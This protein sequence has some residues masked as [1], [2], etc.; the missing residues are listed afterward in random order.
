VSLGAV[1][2][3]N[4]ASGKVGIAVVH[5]GARRVTILGA[6]SVGEGPDDLSWIERWDVFPKGATSVTTIG[7]RPRGQLLADALWV[8]QG[9]SVSA[10]YVWSGNRYG[11]ELHRRH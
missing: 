5:R 3:E 9:D 11:W 1:L 10:F 6:G 2:I 8:G 7:D 4:R